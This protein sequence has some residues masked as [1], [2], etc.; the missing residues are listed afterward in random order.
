MR[1]Y[2]DA[3]RRR[4]V[5]AACVTF[6]VGLVAEA[7]CTASGEELF[8]YPDRLKDGGAGAQGGASS[9]SDVSTVES[10]TST[11]T[12]SSVSS[13]TTGTMCPNG[14]CDPGETNATCPADCPPPGMCSHD[15]CE[16]G[17]ALTMGCDPCVD[18]VCQ[19]D[20]FCCTD[21]WDEQ[22]IGDANDACGNKCCGNGACVGETCTSCEQDCGACTSSG[23]PHTVCFVAE[24]LD[25]AVCHGTCVEAVCAQKSSCCD[26]NGQ[27]W[28]QEC[29]TLATSLCGTADP[30]IVDVCAQMPSCCVGGVVGTGGAGG[31]PGVG[32]AGGAGGMGGATTATSG[33]GGSTPAAWTQACVDLAKTLCSTSCNCAHSVCG[34]SAELAIGCNPCADAVCAADPYCCAT[35]WDG[36]CAGEAVAICGIDCM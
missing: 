15:L 32:G 8:Y 10:A 17:G 36:S 21:S 27:A 11:A 34:Q 28:T 12:A 22:C 35:A 5:A 23:C 25:P 7:A 13:T 31:A 16:M 3:Y 4:A 14:I 33:A 19:N 1:A 9:S 29:E 26:G 30:C 24:A 20:G 2:R 18:A 6:V